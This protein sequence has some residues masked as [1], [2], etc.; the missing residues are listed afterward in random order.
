MNNLTRQ[1]Q[2]ETD[3]SFLYDSIAKI[4]TDESM[5]RVLTSLGDIERR[6]AEAL[7]AKIRT[8]D[9]EMRMPQPS[10]RARTRLFLGKFFGYDSIISGLSAI[11]KNAARSSVLNKQRTGRNPTGFEHNHLKIIEAISSNRKMNVSGGLLSRFE[12]RHRTVGGN[13]LR[14]AVL[15]ANDGLV[16]NLSLVMGIAGAA[17]SDATIMLTG[18]AG[19]LAGAI[20]MALGEW[21]SVQSSTELNLNQIALETDELENSPDEER[22]ELALLYQAKG[23]DV[24]TSEELAAKAFENKESAIGA[25]IVEEL[26]LNQEELSG[27]A[28]EAAIASFVLFAFGA[29]IPVF[30]YFFLEGRSA[31]MLSIGAAIVGLFGIGASITLFTGKS[32]FFSGMRQVLFGLAAAAVTYGIGALIGVSMAG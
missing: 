14:A 7:L 29:I 31:M 13:A 27:S 20:S 3:T 15:G 5:K 22:K 26:G 11:E 28:W 19:L 24:Q 6:H 1:L 17:A 8:T 10:G 9:P 30:P 23:M 25:L 12:G 32:V 2:I 21:L 16:S 18:I 4:Q